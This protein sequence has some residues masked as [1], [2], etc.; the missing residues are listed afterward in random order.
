LRSIRKIKAREIVADVRAGVSD[1]ELMAK[2]ELS[3]QELADILTK[4]VD[5]GRIRK[6]ELE[7]RNPFFDD[8]ANRLQTRRFTRTYLRIPLD[9]KDVADPGRTGLVTDLSKDGFRTRGLVPAF[10]EEKE[11]L[12]G[13]SEVSREIRIRATCVWGKASGRDSRAHEAG[14]KITH[15]SDED[16]REISTI[17][18]FLAL[19]E[20]DV[21]RKRLV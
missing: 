8:P 14:F 6:A 15:V 16:L 13:S 12:I 7:E 1:F 17:V 9:I 19:R 5:A 3:V 11:F 21:S 2:Y 4:L 20:R 18:G 10:G